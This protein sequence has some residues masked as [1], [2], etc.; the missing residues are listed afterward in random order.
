MW[1]YNLKYHAN[2]F[3]NYGTW[4]SNY[5]ILSY[6]FVVFLISGGNFPQSAT[7]HWVSAVYLGCLYVEVWIFKFSV[8]VFVIGFINFV[9]TTVG[10]FQSI[11]F[12]SFSFSFTHV[13][14]C[15]L[16]VHYIVESVN[17]AIRMLNISNMEDTARNL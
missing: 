4:N 13:A 2:V 10:Y 14:L 15:C 11:F 16:V 17:H 5:N 3:L 7:V 8:F 9:L 1:I 6:F 12:V